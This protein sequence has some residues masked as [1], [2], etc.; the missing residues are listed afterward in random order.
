MTPKRK[1]IDEVLK[2]ALSSASAEEMESAS[3]RIFE[4]LRSDDGG[5]VKH[6]LTRLGSATGSRWRSVVGLGAVAAAVI[7]AMWIG[8]SWQQD[9]SVYAVLKT[10]EGTLYRISEDQTIPVRAGERIGAQE[11]VRTN[12]AGGIIALTDGSRVEMRAQ[13]EISLERAADGVRIHLRKGDLLVKAAKQV[14]GHLYVQTKDVTVSVVGTV[15][16]VNAEEEGSR[17]AV[18]EG[19]VRVQHGTTSKNLLPGEEVSTNPALKWLPVHEELSRTRSETHLA[20]LQQPTASQN[21]AGPPLAFEVASIR[22]SAE[23]L[24]KGGAGRGGFGDEGCSSINHFDLDPQRLLARNT[25]L[26]TLIWFAYPEMRPNRVTDC[27]T[28]V[29]ANILTGGPDWILSDQIDLNALI[30]AGTPKYTFNQLRYGEALQL[31]EMLRN[32]L[33]DRV[34]LVL[35]H[36][37]KEMPVYLLTVGKNGARFNGLRPP[38]PG[39]RM[40]VNDANGNVVP[41]TPEQEAARTGITRVGG[42]FDA[43]KVAMSDLATEIYRS[44]ARP[45]LDRT[46]LTGTYDFYLDLVLPGQEGTPRQNRVNMD[47]GTALESLGLKLEESKAPVDVWAIDRVERPSEN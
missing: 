32:L 40:M 14:A 35:R 30:P 3:V 7:A 15:F 37:T 36:E 9:R 41:A 25:T 11:I 21:P 28:L 44:K 24:P 33:K 46:G 47:I 8:V 10:A 5:S 12:E 19:E 27:H 38:V 22:P 2:R 6:P 42:Q 23:R 18:I 16:L 31:H 20:L 1:D 29:E 39:R 13:S 43:R 26:I 34:K 45:V 17:V 4:G